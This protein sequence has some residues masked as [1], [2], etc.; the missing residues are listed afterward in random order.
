MSF[1]LF[2]TFIFS[3][4]IKSNETCIHFFPRKF[5][6]G[7][8]ILSRHLKILDIQ[9]IENIAVTCF[10]IPTKCFKSEMLISKTLTKQLPRPSQKVFLDYFPFSCFVTL[11]LYIST[12]Y[13]GTALKRNWKLAT[14]PCWN[15]LCRLLDCPPPIDVAFYKS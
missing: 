13:G 15:S 8:K 5:A 6:Q 11:I 4:K 12:F 2:T 9:Q 1:D 3:L 14:V 10:I 7:Q